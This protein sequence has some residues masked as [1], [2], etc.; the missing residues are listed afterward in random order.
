[1]SVPCGFS[2]EGLPIGLQLLG[3]HFNEE[4]LLKV[5]YG[6]EGATEFHQK[7]PKL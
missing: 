6:F 3:N 1:M 5:A 7:K 4:M 2:S